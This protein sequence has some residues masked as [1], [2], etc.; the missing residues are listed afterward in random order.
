MPRD[1]RRGT[2]AQLE[3]QLTRLDAER[4][5][6]VSDIRAAVERLTGGAARGSRAMV[7]NVA[8]TVAVAAKPQRRRRRISVEVRERLSKLA[9]ERWAKA[10]RAGKTRLG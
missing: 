6:I 5:R 1:R 9:K 4:H 8:S 7:A 2:L 3:A 10:K